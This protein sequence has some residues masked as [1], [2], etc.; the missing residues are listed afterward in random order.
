MKRSPPTCSRPPIGLDALSR[1]ALALAIV[2]GCLTPPPRRDPADT[3][4]SAPGAA[5]GE[6]PQPLDAGDSAAGPDGFRKLNVDAIFGSEC[7]GDSYYSPL[8]SANLL[9]VLDRSASMACNPPPTTAS[10]DCETNPQRVDATIATKWEITRGA[11]TRAI[12][13]LR[14]ATSV[15]VSYFSNDDACGVHEQ[16]SVPIRPLSDAQR[17]AILASLDNVE[18]AGAT[19]LVGATILAYRHMHSEALEGRIRG[20]KFVVVL[21]DGEQS[22]SCSD[23]A[24]CGNASACTDLLLDEEIPKAS[25]AGVNIRTFVIGAPGSEGARTV[26]SRMASAGETALDGCDPEAGNCH[27]DMT[28]EE[29]FATALESALVEIAG[30]ALTCEL[31]MPKPKGGE[32]DLGLVNVVYSPGSGSTLRVIGRDDSLPCDAGA[33]GWQYA[34][35]NKTIRLCGHSCNT[36]KVDPRARVDVVLGCPSQRPQ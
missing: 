18:P 28:T 15:G 12:G 19:P 4:S 8:V 6:T 9:F 24:H 20:K 31:S 3:Q 21:T 13:A 32:V 7:E 29:D 36:V 2:A 14:S 16:P 5:P 34:D 30:R 22:D 23:P 25:G 35:D 10:A 27:F 1:L 26:L 11:L 33:N 17:S